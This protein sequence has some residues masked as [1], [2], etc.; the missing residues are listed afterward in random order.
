MF[1]VMYEDCQ[2]FTAKTVNSFRVGLLCRALLTQ[3]DK[4]QFLACNKIV[5]PQSYPS[6]C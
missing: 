5:D 6:F 4:K 2:S 1:G 3:W